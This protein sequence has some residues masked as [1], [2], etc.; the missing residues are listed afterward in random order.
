MVRISTQAQNDMALSMTLNAKSN[1]FDLHNQLSTGVKA[2]SYSEIAQDT[3]RLINLKGQIQQ[4]EKFLNNLQIAKERI[5]L[6]SNTLSQI[7]EL[8]RNF[9]RFLKQSLDASDANELNNNAELGQKAKDI[10]IQLTDLLNIRYGDRYIFGGE[11]TDVAPVDITSSSYSSPQD[12]ATF[13]GYDTTQ[14]LS[15]FKG[16]TEQTSL[17]I[18]VNT[19]IEYGVSAGNSTFEKLIRTLDIFAQMDS[20]TPYQFTDPVDGAQRN[21]M[22]DAANELATI[23]DEIKGHSLRVSLEDSSIGNA[24]KCM[25]TSILLPSKMSMK[26]KALIAQKFLPNS[27]RNKISYKLL[28]CHFHGCKT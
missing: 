23:I 26:L 24:K 28:L 16:D 20:S 12:P 4:S 17:R 9:D 2:Q 27:K 25:K 15:Y 19:E 11:V 10:L 22:N 1:I 5:E 21:A 7:S 8:T 18:S 13:G 3:N 6:T 14:N